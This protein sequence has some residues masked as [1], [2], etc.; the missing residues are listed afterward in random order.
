[1]GAKVFNLE[2]EY[3]N[4]IDKALYNRKN[5]MFYDDYED[6]EG[7]EAYRFFCSSKIDPLEFLN[8]DI[9][10]E[11]NNEV[12]GKIHITTDRNIKKLD[13]NKD[14]G[15]II[16]KEVIIRDKIKKKIELR[17]NLHGYNN[18]IS[19]IEYFDAALLKGY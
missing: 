19:V 12:Y 14:Y 18:V 15:E 10:K 5:Y 4:M 6:E 7:S 17:L 8:I 2:K 13:I 16:I 3:I 1:M 9:F 11:N